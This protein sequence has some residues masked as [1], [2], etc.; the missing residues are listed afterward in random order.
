MTIR[1]IQL[2]LKN[3]STPSLLTSNRGSSLRAC[4]SSELS[5]IALRVD[6]WDAFLNKSGSEATARSLSGLSYWQNMIAAKG[7]LV[8]PTYLTVIGC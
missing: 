1:D 5:Y 7:A 4:I 3:G 8:H 2:K 6:Q